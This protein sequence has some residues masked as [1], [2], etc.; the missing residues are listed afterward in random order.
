[1]SGTALLLALAL[2]F[3]GPLALRLGWQTTWVAVASGWAMLALATALLVQGEGAWGLALGT[4]CTISSA[5]LILA[6]VGMTTP[7]PLR[8]VA[9]RAARLR[10]PTPLDPRDVGRRIAV[11]VIV[12]VLDLGAS[13]LLA[14]SLQR[15]LLRLGVLEADA[16]SAAIFILPVVWI[17][18]ASLQMTMNRPLPMLLSVACTG[19][20]GVTT[21]LAT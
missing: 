5:L 19:M 16:V 17:M 8:P 3:A 1:M 11:F 6:Q 14:W 9:D 20:L 15:A 18:L 4:S 21:W 12:A 10:S 7:A 13:V 2:C